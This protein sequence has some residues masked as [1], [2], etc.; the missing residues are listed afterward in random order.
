MNNNVEIANMEAIVA[1]FPLIQKLMEKD[2]AR[3]NNPRPVEFLL[4]FGVGQKLVK[5]TRSEIVNGVKHATSAFG[6]IVLADNTVKSSKGHFFKAGDMLKAAG[7][8][9]PAKNFK[10][11]NVLT[12]NESSRINWT[13]ID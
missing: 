3:L 1:S 12:L 2:F 10:R 8:N 13:G 11:G 9:A 5:I 7:W 4:E 6:F